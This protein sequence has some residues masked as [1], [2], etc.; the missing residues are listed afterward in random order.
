MGW[1]RERRWSMLKSQPSFALL[2]GRLVTRRRSAS[3]V[4]LVV[5]AML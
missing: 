3:V 2:V 1:R 5:V 4:L